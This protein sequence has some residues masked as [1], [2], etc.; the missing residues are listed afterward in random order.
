MDAGVAG[1]ER[2]QRRYLDSGCPKKRH[3]KNVK[4][5]IH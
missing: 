5:F 4:R 1:Q 2:L 3:F